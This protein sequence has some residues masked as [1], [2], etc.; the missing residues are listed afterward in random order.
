M[1]DSTEALLAHAKNVCHLVGQLFQISDCSV[2]LCA[3]PAK[4]KLSAL[5]KLPMK[6]F[7]RLQGLQPQSSRVILL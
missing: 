7:S 2:E 4:A 6:Q 3:D 5:R 1:Y